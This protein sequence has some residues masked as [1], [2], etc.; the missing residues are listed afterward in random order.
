MTLE[1][2]VRIMSEQDIFYPTKPCLYCGKPITCN[3][4]NCRLIGHVC[5]WNG[6]YKSDSGRSYDCRLWIAMIDSNTDCKKH[7]EY[8]SK[9]KEWDLWLEW[10]DETQF[11]P[12][13][14]KS[15]QK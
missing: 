14:I 6:N 3:Q 5:P 13:N 15:E 1:Q 7:S 2:M 10:F 9:H 4:P 12:T 11:I 8:Y